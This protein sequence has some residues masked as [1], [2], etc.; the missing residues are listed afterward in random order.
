MILPFPK[1]NKKIYL[2]IRGNSRN[3]YS[4]VFIYSYYYFYNNSVVD[5]ETH[6]LRFRNTFTATIKHIYCG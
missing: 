2:Y 1:K 4:Y 3:G 5:L 6:L